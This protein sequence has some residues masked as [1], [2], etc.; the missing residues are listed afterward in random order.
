MRLC[1]HP[2]GKP[3]AFRQAHTSFRG[4]AAEAKPLLFYAANGKP[5]AFRTGG[6]TAANEID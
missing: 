3:L 4:Y 1:R 2:C 6:G 5:E